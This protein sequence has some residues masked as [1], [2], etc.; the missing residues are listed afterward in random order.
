MK[1]LMIAACAGAT[2]LCSA[3]TYEEN[4]A[5]ARTPI[6]NVTKDNVEAVC[7]A[8][9]AVTNRTKVMQCRAKGLL[10]FEQVAAMSAGKDEFCSLLYANALYSSNDVLRAACVDSLLAS[11]KIAPAGS[12]RASYNLALAISKFGV[13]PARR[14]EI[15]RELIAAGKLVNAIQPIYGGLSYAVYQGKADPNRQEYGAEY[16]AFCA[17]VFDQLYAAWIAT[18]PGMLLNGRL[19]SG[20]DE[21]LDI[22]RY[23]EAMKNGKFSD[24]AVV[25]KL[26]KYVKDGQNVWT[27]S[28]LND[29]LRNACREAALASKWFNEDYKVKIAAAGDKAFKSKKT[30]EDLYPTLKD[31]VNK[32][33]VALYLG[34]TDKLIDAL[35]T[36]S[37]KL[38]AET[39][40]SVIAPLNGIDAG[41]RTADLRLALMNINKKY[42]LKLYDD[43]DTWEPILSKIRAMIDAL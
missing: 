19:R 36:V 6:D 40:N 1:K 5:L 7:N 37:D 20:W 38:D 29:P 9:L 23:C 30:T 34:D 42:T 10:T 25:A 35:K 28:V 2:M 16:S 4:L 12:F 3:A 31:D 24:S 18:E 41:Y 32:V 27:H 43:R 22:V 21:G 15:G 33:K 26:V 39:V 14:I 8:A 17:E 13:A 11:A